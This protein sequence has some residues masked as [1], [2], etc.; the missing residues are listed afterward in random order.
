MGVPGFQGNDGVP[1][2]K[3]KHTKIK[4]SNIPDHH[5]IAVTL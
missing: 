4:Y 5:V 1:V 3:P 2:S